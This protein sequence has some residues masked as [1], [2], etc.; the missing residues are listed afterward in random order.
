MTRFLEPGDLL[1]DKYEVVRLIG[2]GGMSLVYEARHRR[3]SHSVAL[4]M[5]YRAG[6]PLPE[7]AV[8]FER[9]AQA[10]VR[11]RGRHVAR[12][13]DVDTIEGTPFIVMEYLRGRDLAKELEL[14]GTI[15]AGEAVA[16]VMQAC[17]AMAEAHAL[18]IIH[19]DLKP[20]NLFLTDM[21]VGRLVKV[22]D[23]GISK[24][25]SHDESDVTSTQSSFGTPCYMSPEQVR[26]AKHVDGRSDIWSLGV[27]LYEMLSGEPPYGGETASAT[28]AAIAA[29]TPEPLEALC[30]ELPEGLTAAVMRCLAR[31]P[32]ERFATVEAFA[33]AI[34]PFVDEVWMPPPE[35]ASQP[36]T[37]GVTTMTVKEAP[38]ASRRRLPWLAALVVAGGAAIAAATI[39]TTHGGV[40]PARA[41]EVESVA[42]LEPPVEAAAPLPPVVTAERAAAAAAPTPSTPHRVAPRVYLAPSASVAEAPPPPAPSVDPAPGHSGDTPHPGPRKWRRTFDAALVSE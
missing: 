34:A 6:P 42:A 36:S 30:P 4:K 23:F 25:E 20:A 12:I 22:L 41:V 38:V 14:R 1:L 18:G 11:L 31:D 27:I 15:P 3:L 7:M 28:I 8:R 19:R 24:T 13:H 21:G 39:V 35:R 40:E 29:D 5:L 10:A 17:A 2:Q 26:S 33:A 32:R 9:E 37:P 16:Y